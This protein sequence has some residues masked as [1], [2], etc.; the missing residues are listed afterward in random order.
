MTS[1]LAGMKQNSAMGVLP[2][3][4]S[5]LMQLAEK[6]MPDSL[7]S[8]A[9]Q[10]SAVRLPKLDKQGSSRK[11][12]A[13][14]H[15]ITITQIPYESYESCKYDPTAV[16][17]NF[18]VSAMKGLTTEEAENRLKVYGKN[19][20]EQDPPTPW[21]KVF[22]NQL[23]N[24]LVIMLL[25]AAIVSAALQEIPEC[26]AIFVLVFGLAGMGT[27]QEVSA[28]ESLNALTSM[29]A[30]TATVIRDD[31]AQKDIDSTLLV[32][33]DII[34]LEIG[35]TI[36]AD[37]RLVETTN[38]ICAEA[39]LTGESEGVK[40][41]ANFIEDGKV[42]SKSENKG[43]VM[44][45]C[46]VLEGRA[47]A[48]VVRTGMRTEMGKVAKLMNTADDQ[49]SPLRIQLDK[50]G[51]LLAIMSVVI[52][53][54]VW[55]VGVTTLRGLPDPTKNKY[56]EMTLVAVGLVVA[57]V[58]EGLPVMVTMSLAMGMK[59]MSQ[60]KALCRNLHGTTTLAA[61]TVIC[62]DKTGT[63]TAGA[64]TAVRCWL[65][66]KDYRVTGIGFSTKGHIV[67]EGTN[68][69][70]PVALKNAHEEIALG[71]HL[72]PCAVAA[73]CSNVKFEWQDTGNVQ[74]IGTM[75]EKPLAVAAAKAGCRIDSMT[76]IFP[77]LAENPFDSTRKMMSTLVDVQG[78]A[79]PDE[80]R[81]MGVRS[82]G[83]CPD[84][85]NANCIA[86]VK[87]APNFVLL[88]C[89]RIM[90]ENGKVE[91]LSVSEK[92]EIVEKIDW[93]SGQ[94]LRVL[95]IA[96][97]PFGSVPEDT[98]ANELEAD[99]IL[100]GM[101]AM[102]DPERPEVRPAIDKAYNAGIRVVAIS[103]D[104]TKTLYAICKNIGLLSPDAPESK[105]LDCE[106]IRQDGG[107][108]L[109]IEEILRKPNIGDNIPGLEAE[110]EVINARLDKITSFVDAFGRAKPADKITILKS[111][112][113]QGHIA[114]MTGDG[115][116]DAPALKQANIG[117][118]MGITGTDAAKAAS[119][120]VLTDDSFSSIV[121]GVQ[122]GR[123]IFRNIAIFIYLLL[124]ENIGEAIFCLVSPA[125]L[126]QPL[127]LEAIQLLLLNLFTDG[128]PAIALAVEDCGNE[129]LMN[130]GPRGQ[131]EFII[132]KIMMCGIFL[133]S[134]VLV[135]LCVLNYT[136]ALVRHTGN[137][138]GLHHCSELK[139]NQA[140][141]D[142]AYHLCEWTDENDVC[143]TRRNSFPKKYL[144]YA[145]TYHD[146][147][148]KLRRAQTVVYLFILFAE[149]WRAYTARSLRE[150]IFT[151][152]FFSN[153]WMFPAVATGAVGG[154]S[155]ALIP[156]LRELL[157]FRLVYDYKDWLWIILTSFIPC[158]F[159]EF[160][161]LIYRQTNFG[162]R[163][164]ATRGN[165]KQ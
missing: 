62:S 86:C 158:M 63:L 71:V 44:M 163:A 152:G 31:G 52:A 95:A 11:Q 43:M 127:P 56:L 91:S 132:S 128:A 32:P 115:V 21:W 20:L 40:K 143:F 98:T 34:I 114:S 102:I 54:I 23:A 17:E 118:A 47:K 116:N 53:V 85:G 12:G 110:L 103:G 124:S 154:V 100:V 133:H 112:Q 18:S 126:G 83:M 61:C 68:M 88:N 108:S 7:G 89:T 155:C 10:G 165:V 6:A 65:S 123:A 49:A 29:S 120:I 51:K 82:L 48:V 30:P 125:I 22:L 148:D 38:L 161:K 130:E 76:T 101:F 2:R 135:V 16:C 92:N 55:I 96:A 41:D 64:M 8:P 147:E 157:G 140:C 104:Y 162:I 84:L 79:D 9:R 73:L 37:C 93:Y 144:E 3:R 57:A 78:K 80:K 60:Q 138:R 121:A 145:K 72:V 107:R 75:T 4:Q 59:R 26:V 129:I 117:V 97:R 137:W 1:S 134:T 119:S 15:L 151:M 33:G 131:K 90:R 136:L 99:L 19:E 74:V 69:D 87:G 46:T 36:P 28:G 164:K 25:V 67:P 66:G 14:E 13:N 106:V 149:L 81:D 77:R 122:E 5:L 105:V 35:R 58:P 113:R 39:V 45:G 24:L 159:E 70:D 150:S 50:L 42:H 94:A 142:S 160:V 153:R 156:G 109:E 111:L 141:A 27:Y 139:T 146:Y